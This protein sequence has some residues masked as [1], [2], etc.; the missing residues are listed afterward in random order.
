MVVVTILLQVSDAAGI[1]FDFVRTQNDL[2]HVRGILASSTPTRKHVNMEPTGRLDIV[3][4]YNTPGM[5]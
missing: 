5:A 1:R 2:P 3:G 4:G